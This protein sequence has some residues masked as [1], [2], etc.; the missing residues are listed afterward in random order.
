VTDQLELSGAYGYNDPK[1]DRDALSPGGEKIY[2]KDSAVP[3]AG[4]PSTISLSGEYSLPIGSYQGYLRA[5][6]THTSE[7]RRVGN[8][9]STSPLYDARRKPIPAYSL[10]N[11]RLGARFDKLDVS[12][13]VQNVTNA[14]PALYLSSGRY[15]DPQDWQM[16][17]LRPRTY[18]LTVAWR[19]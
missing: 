1:F 17:T 10:L 11:A 9:V 13:F 15:Y 2:A 16:S 18:G 4:A 14:R 12:L 6:F 8:E 5:D 3:D 7:W 19:Q